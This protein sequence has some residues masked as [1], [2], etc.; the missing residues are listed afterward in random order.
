MKRIADLDLDG[1]AIGGL[2]VG[3]PKEEMYR[4]IGEVEPYMPKDKIRYLMGVGTPGNIL[5]GVKLGVDLF[6][7]VMPSRN[8]RHGHLFT[9]D[10]IINLNNAKYTEDFEPIDHRCTCEACTHHSRAY[11]RHLLKA[12]EML[13]MRL[14]VT[15]N[16]H[17]F[18]YNKQDIISEEIRMNFILLDTAASTAS[19]G[20]FFGSTWGMLVLIGGMFVLMYFLMIRPQNKQRKAEE[21]MRNNVEIGDDVVTI[22]G[23]VGK[24]VS[25][26]DDALIIETGADRN[27]MK[28][29]RWAVQTNL[30]KQA[31]QQEAAQK[32]KEAKQKAKEEKKKAKENKNEDK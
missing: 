29:T 18:I 23:I 11:I 14:A 15:H 13:G 26:K 19:K 17:F 32:A 24:V 10:G 31:A 3:E 21:E 12:G 8:A 7:C 28:V 1:Y 4:I 25:T 20:G 5:T 30:T 2:A 6:D 16:L 27:K 22:G 9:W